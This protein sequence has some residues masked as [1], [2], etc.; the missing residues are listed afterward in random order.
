[1][2][3]H[4]CS[5]VGPVSPEYNFVQDYPLYPLQEGDE[6]MEQEGDARV[7]GATGFGD[8]LPERLWEGMDREQDTEQ[9]DAH[10]Q[11]PGD[12]LHP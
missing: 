9:H 3:C 4:A 8:D 11:Q 12:E 7:E 6:D 1:M 2:S 10:A 5:H